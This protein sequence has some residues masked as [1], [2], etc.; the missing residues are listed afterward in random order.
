MPENFEQTSPSDR[1]QFPRVDVSTNVKFIM[2]LPT[3][4]EGIT[5]DISQ[6]GMCLM[7]KKRM[8]VGSLMQLK[9]DL[10]GDNPEHIE[11]VGR[12]VWV[13]EKGDGFFLIGV[14]FLS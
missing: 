12:A 14:K 10:P 3:I 1:R 9:F 4:E 13:K 6:G 7:T 2:L 8:E 11:V 5:K